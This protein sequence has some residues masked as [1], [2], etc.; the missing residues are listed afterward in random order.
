MNSTISELSLLWWKEMKTE[1]MSKRM[2]EKEWKSLIENYGPIVASPVFQMSLAVFSYVLYIV[3]FTTM[4]LF[5]V[6]WGKKIQEGRYPQGKDL[7]WCIAIYIL[8]QVVLVGPAAIIQLYLGVKIDLPELAPTYIEFLFHTAII[9]VLHDFYF[10]ATHRF[11]HTRFM[12]K[13]VHYLHH[14]YKHP[15][16]LTT[17]YLH[18]IEVFI[19]GVGG[20]VIP[21]AI[22]AHPIT[23]WVWFFII[24][25][26]SVEGHSGYDFLYR[27]S[28]GYIAG[29]AHHDTHHLLHNYNFAAW[30]TYWD[31][32][33]DSYHPPLFTKRQQQKALDV[34]TGYIIPKSGSKLI[35]D[36]D[37]NQK[38]NNNNN[39]NDNNQKSNNNNN[40]QKSNNNNQKSNNNN[41]NQKSNNSKPKNNNKNKQQKVKQN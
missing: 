33:N 1:I 2:L 22:G 24:I 35:D 25:F 18:P 13:Y 40:N 31:K 37:K 8:N 38:S 15:F 23:Q 7:L 27:F 16:A 39:N 4:D 28:F 20:T 6:N 36:N 26:Y 5:Q 12:Y 21:M 19:Q 10:Y 30:F 17:Q 29:S 32:L 41:N 3:I 34:G 11:L 9:I 14:E